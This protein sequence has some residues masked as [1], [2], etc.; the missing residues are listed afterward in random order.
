MLTPK[1]LGNFTAKGGLKKLIKVILQ[2]KKTN[3]ELES[4]KKINKTKKL[5]PIYKSNSSYANAIKENNIINKKII[6]DQ[7]G[8]GSYDPSTSFYKNDVQN[9]GSF[10]KRFQEKKDNLYYPGVGAYSLQNSYSK[11]PYRYIQS[12]VPLN[13]TRKHLEGISKDRFQE[14]KYQIYSEKYKQPGV[15]GYFPEVV[16]CLDYKCIKK[17]SK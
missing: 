3:N 1:V 9:F 16:N 17:S 5:S 10:E 15:G 6:M 7:I 2:K 13:I 12:P 14:M 4:K 8:P 11:K